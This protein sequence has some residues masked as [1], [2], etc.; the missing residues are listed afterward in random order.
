L[1][2]AAVFGLLLFSSNWIYEKLLIAVP[3]KLADE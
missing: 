3:G 2:L 1:L